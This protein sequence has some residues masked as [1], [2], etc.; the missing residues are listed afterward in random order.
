MLK[1][2]YIIGGLRVKEMEKSNMVKIKVGWCSM[3]KLRMILE[4]LFFLNIY[5]L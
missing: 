1:N 4:V 3:K 2:K 5:L